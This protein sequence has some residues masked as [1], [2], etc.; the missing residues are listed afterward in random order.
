MSEIVCQVLL[1]VYRTSM[2]RGKA[3][4]YWYKVSLSFNTL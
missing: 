2:E 3:L 1:Q 4:P